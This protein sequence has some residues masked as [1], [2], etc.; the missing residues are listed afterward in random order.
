MVSCRVKPTL[1]SMQQVA[2]EKNKGLPLNVDVLNIPNSC[3]T[4]LRVDDWRSEYK[5]V[6]LLLRHLSR[7]CKSEG[8]RRAY[9][10]RVYLF[11]LDTGMQPDELVKTPKKVIQN[12]IQ[13]HVDNFNDGEHSLRYLNTMIGL[14]K[15]FFTVNGF[16][17]AR[18]LNLESYHVSTRYRKTPEYIPKKNEVYLMAD[19]ACSLKGR[20][21]ILTLYSSGLRNSTLRAL[22]VRDIED[23]L[24]RNISNLC[25]PVYPEMKL[26]DGAACKGN[27]P[28]FVFVCDEATEAIRLYFRE[29]KERYGEI[30]GAEPLFISEYNQIERAGRKS[31]VMSPRQLE[32][33]VKMAAQRAGLPKWR[34]VTPKSLRKS[35]ETILHSELV[36]GGRL[37]P[38]I[39]EFFMGHILP[40][41]E[42]AYFDKTDIETL[43]SEYAKLCF[44]RVAVSNKF[45][46]LKTAIERAF[47][48]TG[49]DAEKT[50][51]EYVQ[52]QVHGIVE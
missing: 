28:Y 7:K 10:R 24:S 21:I 47:Q 23:E 37:D 1:M 19:S 41:S 4:F 15:T 11:C 51:R 17:G 42:D 33:I 27:I 34:Y 26:V 38:K 52:M 14:L 9:L 39:Q 40:G 16:K 49:I 50:I 13:D 18:V 35:F 36:D 5:S 20:A 46:I 30:S 22:L 12:L 8:S 48:G 29:R 43:R 2:E 31:K 25:V 32:N 44:G 3:Y 45:K 6:D